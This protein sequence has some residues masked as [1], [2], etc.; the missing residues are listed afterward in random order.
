L[1]NVTAIRHM[2]KYLEIKYYII[3]IFLG[4]DHRLLK[5]FGTNFQNI[6]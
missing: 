3:F 1:K 5:P 2:K 6:F 4:F